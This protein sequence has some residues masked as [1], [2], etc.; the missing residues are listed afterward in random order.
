ME[1]FRGKKPLGV[2]FLSRMLGKTFD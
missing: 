1:F 2:Q